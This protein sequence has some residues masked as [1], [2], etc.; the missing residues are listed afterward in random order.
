MKMVENPGKISLKTKFWRSQAIF[1]KHASFVHFRKPE[2]PF[3]RWYIFGDIEGSFLRRKPLLLRK[4]LK[5]HVHI[6]NC[7]NL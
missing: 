7:L 1:R 5:L 3:S 2:K 4:E 6:V